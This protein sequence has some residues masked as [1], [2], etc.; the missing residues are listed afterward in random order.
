MPELFVGIGSNADPERR[1]RAAL[2]AL[3]LRFGALGV[4]PIFRSGAVG[5]P[6][7]DYWNLA[8]RTTTDLGPGAVK[9]ELRAIESALGRTRGDPSRCE[10]DLDLLIHGLRVDGALRLP[11][12]D[13]LSKRFVL[14]PLALLAPALRHPVTGERLGLVWDRARALGAGAELVRVD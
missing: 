6:A 3:E 1:V 9:L 2:A 7:P 8:V 11:H 4:S 13:V 14:Q 5:G 10:I 12:P